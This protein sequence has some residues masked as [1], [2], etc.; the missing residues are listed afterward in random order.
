M[1]AVLT[2]ASAAQLI[3]SVATPLL[4][5]RVH[6]VK[7]SS[8]RA[9]LSRL[10]SAALVIARL[11]AGLL[12]TRHG[13]TQLSEDSSS[14]EA[15]LRCIRNTRSRPC[16]KIYPENIDTTGLTHLIFS[17]ATIDPDTFVVGPMHPDDEKLYVDFLNL[18]DGSKKW[19]GIGKSPASSQTVKT[20]T[21]HRRLGVL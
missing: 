10:R 20:P 19:I 16:D 1:F 6:P 2:S 18:N 11:R 8:A 12:T 21:R 14:S 5:V 9:A 7:S 4:L 17:F 15:S 3:L 13:R